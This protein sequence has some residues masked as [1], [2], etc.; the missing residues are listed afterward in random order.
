MSTPPPAPRI[1]PVNEWWKLRVILFNHYENIKHLIKLN[2][3]KLYG[4][5]ISDE[6][7]S[8]DLQGENVLFCFSHQVSLNNNY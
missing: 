5:Y 8:F 6:D 2:N 3:L 4:A 1:I 7:F